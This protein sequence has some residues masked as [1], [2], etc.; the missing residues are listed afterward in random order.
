MNLF[1]LYTCPVFSPSGWRPAGPQVRDRRLAEPL[2]DIRQGASGHGRQGH[3]R[4]SPD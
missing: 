1:S 3:Q 2:P 4:D